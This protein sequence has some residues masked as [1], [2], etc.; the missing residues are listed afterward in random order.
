MMEL[1]MNADERGFIRLVRDSA[2]PAEL[3][4]ISL[5]SLY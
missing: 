5:Q 2:N 1:R 3:R 4:M